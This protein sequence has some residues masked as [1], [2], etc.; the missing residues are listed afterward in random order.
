MIHIFLLSYIR[1]NH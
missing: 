1:I